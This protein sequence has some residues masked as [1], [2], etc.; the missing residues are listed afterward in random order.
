MN[1]TSEQT[2]PINPRT[3]QP[4]KTLVAVQTI[5][6]FV[7]ELVNT[8][9]GKDTMRAFYQDIRRHIERNERNKTA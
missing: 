3:G 4:Y 6:E 8:S 1:K 5:D 7:D 2:H 9:Q